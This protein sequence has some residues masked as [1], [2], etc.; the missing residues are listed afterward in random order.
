VVVPNKAGEETLDTA[1]GKGKIRHNMGRSLVIDPVGEI[2]A[3]GSP[4]QWEAVMAK[5]DLDDVHKTQKDLPFWRDRRPSEY[6]R[7]VKP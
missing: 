3:E 2:I 1:F 7:L 4:D 5:V 6:G